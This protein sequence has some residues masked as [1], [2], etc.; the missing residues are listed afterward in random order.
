MKSDING[1]LA[2]CFQRFSFH[3]ALIDYG[4]LTKHKLGKQNNHWRIAT[5]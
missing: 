4:E 3:L 1:T 2:A 5:Q